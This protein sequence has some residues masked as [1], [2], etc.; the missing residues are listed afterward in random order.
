MNIWWQFYLANEVHL[1]VGE[2]Y[3]GEWQFDF[4][5]KVWGDRKDND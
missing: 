2:F 3:I 5:L 4:F 1:M